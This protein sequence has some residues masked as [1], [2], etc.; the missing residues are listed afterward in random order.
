MEIPWSFYGDLH[1]AR[2]LR[3][4]GAQNMCTEEIE[5]LVNHETEADASH[6]YETEPQTQRNESEEAPTMV[7]TETFPY[8]PGTY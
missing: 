3:Q 1:Y 4:P 6:T 5:C 7:H 2:T 8:L